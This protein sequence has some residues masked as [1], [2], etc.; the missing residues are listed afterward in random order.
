MNFKFNGK[1]IYCSYLGVEALLVVLGQDG[2]HTP[3]LFAITEDGICDEIERL[4][5][6]G[7]VDDWVGPERIT[8]PH[9]EGDLLSRGCLYL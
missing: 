5:L 4:V 6:W 3:W 2:S 8:W 9:P 1:T 7:A